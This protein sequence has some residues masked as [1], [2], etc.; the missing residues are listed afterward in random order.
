MDGASNDVKGVNGVSNLL[1]YLG[2]TGPGVTGRGLSGRGLSGNGVF[3]A[4][5]ERRQAPFA[6]V[7]GGVSAEAK[8]RA[9][10]AP[11]VAD[12]IAAL[13]RLELQE[14]AGRTQEAQM[15]PRR[16]RNR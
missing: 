2:D 8:P 15:P 11:T 3:R 14:L 4:C 9:A 10:Q 7:L 12:T 6:A 16:G 13:P 1:K 5:P